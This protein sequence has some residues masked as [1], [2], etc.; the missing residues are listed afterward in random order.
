M[1]KIFVCS[2]VIMMIF[3]LTAC[4]LNYMDSDEIQAFFSNLAEDLGSSQITDDDKLI[5]Q[6]VTDD[7]YTG[8]YQSDCS[9]NTGRDVIFGGGSIEE[10]TLY[11]SG[12]VKAESGSAIVRTRLNDEV[13]ELTPD[14]NGIFETELSLASGG[15]YI[16]VQYEDFKGTV[17][18]SS[19]YVKS[20]IN[21]KI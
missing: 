6:R 16:M 13:I 19:E 10:R 1:K 2:L 5:G 11:I 12:A 7:A 15:N 8:T 17:E 9:G 4:R 3:S 18:L 14:E 21:Y 20:S